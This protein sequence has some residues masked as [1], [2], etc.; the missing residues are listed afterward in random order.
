MEMN[1]LPTASVGCEA[2]GGKRFNAGTLEIRYQGK[3]IAEVLQLSV[4]EAIEF[5]RTKRGC[6]ALWKP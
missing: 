2:C 1:F 5:L 3:S 4:A 6:A